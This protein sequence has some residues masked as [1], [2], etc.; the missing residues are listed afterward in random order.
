MQKTIGA[1]I[2]IT[3]LHAGELCGACSC[4][5]LACEYL[6]LMKCVWCSLDATE[7]REEYGVAR[8]INHSKR[9]A[10]VQTRRI[11]INSV[12]RLYFVASRDIAEG[13]ELLYDYGDKR[14]AVVSHFPW[15]DK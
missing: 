4:M 14:P 2:C 8:L 7:E 6:T 15:L 3:S 5:A 10:N 12:P 9:K 13:E 11:T 1:A